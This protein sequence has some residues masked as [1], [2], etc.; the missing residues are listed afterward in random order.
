MLGRKTSK[1]SN[2][3]AASLTSVLATIS[4]KLL[5]HTF[6]RNPGP[7]LKRASVTGLDNAFQ[8]TCT[9]VRIPSR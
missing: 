2:H 7:S 5:A 3:L 4:A 6:T 1:V 8:P 9:P